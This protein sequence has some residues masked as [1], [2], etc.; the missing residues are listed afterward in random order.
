[1]FYHVYFGRMILPTHNKLT[2][3]ILFSHEWD[4][5]TG[6]SQAVPSSPGGGM[7]N[8]VHQTSV[9]RGAA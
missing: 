3:E 9:S 6:G 1:M 8:Q 4:G 2:S 7:R 5:W